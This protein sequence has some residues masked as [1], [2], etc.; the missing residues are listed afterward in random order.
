MQYYEAFKFCPVCGSPYETGSW[1]GQAG[2]LHCPACSYRFY[3]NSK[4]SVCAVVPEQGNPRRILMIRRATPPHAG[5]LCL[6]GGFLGYGEDPAAGAQRETLEETLLNTRASRLI[7]PSRINYNW[8]GAV[9]EVLELSWLMEP[10]T[11][12]QDRAISEEASCIAFFDLGA[13]LSDRESFAFP[14]Q[15]RVVEDYLEHLECVSKR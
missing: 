6:P 15:V 5:K 2:L 7:R 9:V 1:D 11:L 12:R 8:G 4:P 3:Q 10:V 14:E 13:L